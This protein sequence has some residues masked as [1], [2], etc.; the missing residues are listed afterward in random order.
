MTPPRPLLVLLI[1]ALLVGTAAWFFGAGGGAAVG[2][3]VLAAVSS[4]GAA[5]LSLRPLSEGL[6]RLEASVRAPEPPRVAPEPEDEV[7]EPLGQAVAALGTRMS[8]Q[9]ETLIT[10]A[11]TLSAVLDGMIE[12]VWVTDAS[13]T[14]VRHNNALKELLYAGKDLVGERPLALLR[15]NDLNDA[16]MKACREGASS[17]LE[18]T[19]DG[20]RPRTLSVNVRPLGGDMPGSSA[21]F[22]DITELRRLEQIR[23]DFVANVSHE[24][25]TPITAIRGY[26]ETLKAGALRDEQN[27]PQ[28]VDIIHRQ[29]ERLSE[30]VSDLLELSQLES[31]QLQLRTVDVS[32]K[33]LAERAAD[34]VRPKAQGK[35]ITVDLDISGDLR[36][37]ADDRAVEQVLINLLDNAVKYTPAGGKV[38]VTGSTDDEGVR[39]QVQDSGVGIE[40]KHLPRVFERFYRVDKGRS[41]D[42]GG[43]G[44]GLSI[45]KHLTTAMGGDVKVSSQPG[46]G[47]IFSVVL[48][49]AGNQPATIE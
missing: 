22:H 30:L 15:R 10:Q 43:T 29:S 13:G 21:V 23:K 25:R 11:N 28:M 12:G 6:R 24:L 16:V 46:V 19:L 36:A 1:P 2:A 48:P 37:S 45:V 4:Y 17:Q 39:V 18:V 26:S 47:S 7:L 49:S 41:R 34:A 9:V 33:D 44:L 38:R 40:T 31:G 32:L 42:M 14:L 8:A 35:G 3:A 20:V 5:A 27:A